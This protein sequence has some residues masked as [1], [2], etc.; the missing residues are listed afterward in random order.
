M[1]DPR[2]LTELTFEFQLSREEYSQLV[3]L[4]HRAGKQPLPWLTEV[5]HAAVSPVADKRVVDY[6]RRRRV[7]R[8]DMDLLNVLEWQ[9]PTAEQR[10]AS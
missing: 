3:V 6:A 7:H 2:A 10:L 8:G 5:I 4:A 1:T 9:D